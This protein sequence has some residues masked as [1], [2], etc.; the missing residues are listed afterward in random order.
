MLMEVKLFMRN[1]IREEIEKRYIEKVSDLQGLVED[2]AGI[3]DERDDVKHELNSLK[4]KYAKLLFLYNLKES[5]VS[6]LKHNSWV[7][8]SLDA[9]NRVL[10][11][12][13]MK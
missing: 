8:S 1:T 13:H 3:E 5:D 11:A 4:S 2:L 12:S 9:C 7:F 6:A 10:E